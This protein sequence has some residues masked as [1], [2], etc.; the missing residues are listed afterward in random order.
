MND[1]PLITP[2]LKIGELLDAFPELESELIAIAPE[3]ERLRNPLLRRTVA[4]ITTL[5]QAARVGGV[6]LGV[7]IN[8]LRAAAGQ[9]GAFTATDPTARQG[10][11]PAWVDQ[12][13]IVSTNDARAAISAGAHPLP[14][15]MAAVK[16]LAP[17][18][19]HVLVTPFV[20]APLLD[21]VRAQGLQVWTEAVGPE[22]FRNLFGRIAD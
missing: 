14:E 17:G 15:V 18:Q 8:R 21:K 20:P 16:A 12:M 19:A 4:R 9:E 5:E 3:F 7:L 1:R 11:R 22:E 10:D 13:E 6:G 2:H